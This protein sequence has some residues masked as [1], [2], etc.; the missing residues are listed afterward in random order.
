MASVAARQIACN[1][2][3]GGVC[4]G[5]ER[6]QPAKATFVKSARARLRVRLGVLQELLGERTELR[7]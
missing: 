5:S 7:W 1:R 4:D 2:V 3:Q 6:Q